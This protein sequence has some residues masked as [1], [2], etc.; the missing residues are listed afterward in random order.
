MSITKRVFGKTANG[1]EAYIFTLVNSKGMKAEITNYGGIVVSL[2]APDSK[3]NFEDVVLGFDKLED[4][5]TK[6]TY[7]G[8]IVGRH[9]NRIENASF[10]LNGVEYK[11]AKN[12]G[13]NSLHG[14]VVGFDKVLW[15]AEIAN[16]DGQECLELTYTSV[17]GEEG[18]PGNLDVKVIYTLTEDNALKIDYFAVSDKDTV[19]NLTNHSFFNLSGHAAGSIE[20]HEV[21]INAT[22]FTVGNKQVIPTG[23]IADVKGTPM[24]LTKLTSLEPGLNSQYDQIVYAGGYDHNWV[25]DIKDK[26]VE[27]AAEVFDPSSRRVMEVYTNK[28]GIQLYTGNFLD[29]TCVGKGGAVYHK[30]NGLCL[31]TQYYPN[32]LKHKHFPSPILKAGEQYN[33]T[34]IYKFL[35]K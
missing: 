33:F 34:T 25:L 30:R 31:E 29:G 22:K 12:D 19:V 15:K 4:Y 21:M 10:E 16:K 20:K 26:K 23:E 13:E 11:L 1:N 32:S 7:F 3:G 28:P 5:L 17:D 14:G 2:T 8:A 18:F 6:N 24:D 9:A 35:A 27:K